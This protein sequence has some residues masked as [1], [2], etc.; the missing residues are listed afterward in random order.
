MKRSCRYLTQAYIWL[1]T[2][3]VCFGKL[4]QRSLRQKPHGRF[5]FCYFFF[6]CRLWKENR[7]EM[8]CCWHTGP[9]WRTTAL[10]AFTLSHKFNFLSAPAYAAYD[11]LMCEFSLQLLCALSVGL[12]PQTKTASFDTIKPA[13][14]VSMYVC[15]VCMDTCTITKEHKLEVY[16]SSLLLLFF[17]F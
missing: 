13:V 16:Y 3:V 7:F 14:C 9:G 15:T 8:Y 5:F 11:C 12:N 10:H 4:L 2:E 6:F 17:L 1:H